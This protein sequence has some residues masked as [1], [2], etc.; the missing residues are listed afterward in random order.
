[1]LLGISIFGGMAFAHESSPQD[2]FISDTADFFNDVEID[3]GWLP[4]SGVISL[5][6]QTL[7]NGG[8]Y[9][10][11]EGVADLS[12]DEAGQIHFTPEVDSGEFYI[13]SEMEFVVS[14]RFD[15]NFWSWDGELFSQGISFENEST[16]NP[17]VLSD[18]NPDRLEL[19]ATASG[20][21]VFDYKLE[22]IPSIADVTFYLEIEP[23]LDVGYEGIGWLLD[24]QLIEESSEGLD[25][26]IG[27]PYVEFEPSHVGAFDAELDM[28]IIPAVEVCVLFSCVDWQPI[29]FPLQ[30]ISERLE[31]IFPPNEL[32]FPLPVIDLD[33]QEVDVGFIP[34]GE[35]L[36]VE[37]PIYNDGEW[38]LEGDVVLLGAENGISVFPSNF[39]AAGYEEDGIS[40]IFS[41]E[42]SGPIAT[43]VQ[44]FS[45]DP[46]TPLIEID[47]I[48]YAY[49]KSLPSDEEC[50]AIDVT[51]ISH[52]VSGCGCSSPS[53]NPMSSIWFA[54]SFVVV[55][56]RRKQK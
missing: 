42:Y 23:Q 38:Y 21:K 14:L 1:M 36:T 45:N 24:G 12:W 30:V 46:N 3:S 54:L 10:E 35:S 48:G 39:L 34:I 8:A 32:H 2:V 31:Q 4:A 49:S 53:P 26:I 55:M 11:A 43:T 18:E 37:L 44:L 13:E 27:G 22:V 15:I 16:F 6:F 29:E 17:F 41:P 52:Q 50:E 25:V 56:F 20:T 19:F 47:I 7:T 51:K 9:I 28:A 33:N 5:R 40:V